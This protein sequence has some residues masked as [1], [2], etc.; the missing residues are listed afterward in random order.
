MKLLAVIAAL[1]LAPAASASSVTAIPARIFFGDPVVVTATGNRA[2]DLDLGL[3]TTLAAPETENR[4][5]V[6]TVTQRVIC[7]AEGCVPSGVGRSVQLP[8]ASAGGA[9]GRARILVAPR[10]AAAAVEAEK[11]S[12]VRNTAVAPLRSHPVVVAALAL[13]AVVLLALAAL[14]LV[15]RR[16]GAA[17]E[18]VPQDAL[19]R[20]ARLLRESAGRP[21]PDRRRAADLVGRVAPGLA[22]PARGIAWSRLDPRTQDVEELAARVEEGR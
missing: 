6:T 8:A 10:V 22:V 17:R 16:R 7:L 18:R 20:A 3:W 15:P 1:S 4:A 19:V 9:R 14:S 11:A 12:Y 2:V 21:A 13:G 5:G